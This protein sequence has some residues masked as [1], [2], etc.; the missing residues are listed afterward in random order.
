MTTALAAFEGTEGCAQAPRP[1]GGAW[2]AF[3]AGVFNQ[4][5]RSAV[6]SLSMNF[7]G[8][9]L[10]S[11]PGLLQR[12]E[13]AIGGGRDRKRILRRRYSREPGPGVPHKRL[14]TAIHGYFVSFSDRTAQFCPHKF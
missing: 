5:G 3:S 8:A 1:C 13:N 11:S 2:L 7:R 10:W 12:S 9:M 4:P 6:N 14:E